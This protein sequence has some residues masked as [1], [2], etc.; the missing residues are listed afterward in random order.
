MSLLTSQ[1]IIGK[2]SRAPKGI[3][4]GPPGV[5]KTTFGASAPG[6]Y[7]V[8]CENGAGSVACARSPYLQTWPQMKA[9]LA[10]LEREQ[11]NHPVI[12][13]DTIDWMVRRIKEFT[14]GSEKDATKTLQRSHGGYGNGKLVMEN[15]IYGELLP[16]FDRI[17]SRGIAVVLLAH[18]KR[19]ALTDVDGISIE[20]TAPDILPDLLNVFV[21]WSDFVCLARNDRENRSLQTVGNNTVLAKN[22]Y[23]MPPSLPLT[24]QSFNSAIT[25][26]MR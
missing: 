17:V 5:G 19:T 14:Q 24:W 6:A 4:Y 8:D 11:H 16:L 9:F 12:V 26:G 13:V 21:E 15:H 25:A 2:R 18:A 7:L 3:I 23:Q 22:R 1:S 10:D 20:T